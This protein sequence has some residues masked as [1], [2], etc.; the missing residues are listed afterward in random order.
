MTWPPS[1]SM[2]SNIVK[3]KLHERRA[4]ELG[5]DDLRIERAAAIGG[6]VQLQHANV[7][8]LGVDL[9]LRRRRRRSSRT[10]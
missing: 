10:A 2:F 9:D 8:G 5:L 4:G 7:A 6:V 3:P 1:N